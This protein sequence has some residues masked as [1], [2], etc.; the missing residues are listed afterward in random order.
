M[1]ELKAEA[2]VLGF[3]V[4]GETVK[5]EAG[6]MIGDMKIRVTEEEFLKRLGC[7]GRQQEDRLLQNYRR[8]M[9]LGESLLEP[10]VIY[11]DFP[12]SHIEGERIYLDG[13]LSFCSKHLVKVMDGAERVVIMCS[14]IGPAL[15]EKVKSL[16]ENGDLMASYLLD[17]YGATAISILGKK[18]YR[19]LREQYE[20]Q[21]CGTTVRIQPGQLDWDVC[22]QAVIFQLLSPEKIGVVLTESFMMK[23]VKSS[24]AVFGIGDPIKVKKGKLSCETCPLNNKCKFRDEAEE[25]VLEEEEA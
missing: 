15:E 20:D 18:L 23:P 9:E 12:I 1:D 7:R 2:A 14:T 8:V 16:N 24:T 6:M 4:S 19:D 3:Q 10:Q 21:G 13:S 25:L 5:K 11:E 22:A 17:I